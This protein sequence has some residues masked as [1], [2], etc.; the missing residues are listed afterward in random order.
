L[1]AVALNNY[2]LF[3]TIMLRKIV[4]KTAARAGG[5]LF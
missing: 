3:A 2:E 1:Q 5:G 4:H